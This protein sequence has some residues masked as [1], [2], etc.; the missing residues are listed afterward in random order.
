MESKRNWV[1]IIINQGIN[2]IFTAIFFYPIAFFW[3]K[4]YHPQ[5]LLVV[6]SISMIV[7]FIPPK[8]YMYAQLSQSKAFYEN[9]GIDKF[10]HLTQQGKFA[11]RIISYLSI[12]DSFRLNKK[13]ITHFKN[14]IRTF[15]SY[16]FA[17][18]LFFL[19]TFI[20]AF[21]MKEYIFAIVI[22][23]ANILYNIIPILIQQYNKTRISGLLK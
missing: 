22:F 10:Q 4:F 17:C 2:L 5:I 1:S 6:L 9:F 8:L 20:Y 21:I 15:E 18:L 23:I 19:G 13:S 12:K 16:H 3:F 11:E 14:Q 7:F